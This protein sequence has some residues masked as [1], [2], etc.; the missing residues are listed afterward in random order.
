MTRIKISSDDVMLRDAI[1]KALAQHVDQQHE[2]EHGIVLLAGA[3]MQWPVD[4]T[5]AGYA[6]PAEMVTVTTDAF[7]MSFEI[8][9]TAP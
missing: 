1:R 7:S 9:L 2:H 8:E 4:I 6:V 5:V 3:I